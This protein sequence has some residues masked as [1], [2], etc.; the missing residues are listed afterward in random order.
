MLFALRFGALRGDVR[1]D[2]NAD[3]NDDGKI[4]GVD[5]AILAT[6]FGR[7]AATS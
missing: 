2:A 4:D 3:F 5:L 1:Y 7:T 6:N